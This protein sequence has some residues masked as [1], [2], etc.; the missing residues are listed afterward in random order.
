MVTDR[1]PLIGRESELAELQSMLASSPLVSITGTGGC[2]KTRLALETGERI[3]STT[4]VDGYV[5]AALADVSRAD[6]LIEALVA[7]VGVRERFG[8]TPQE[9]LLEHLGSRR[10]L[11]VLDNCEHLLLDVALLAREL[12]HRAPSLRLLATSR[13]PLAIDGENVLRL[14][15]LSLPEPDDDGVGAIVRSD[16]GRMFVER[17]VRRDAAFALTPRTA[18]AVA[19]ICRELDGLPLALELAAARLDTLSV[20]Q[21]ARELGGKGRLST[22]GT[23]AEP[24]RHSSLRASLDWSYRLLDETERGLLR[25]L[26]VFSGEFNTAAAHGIAAPGERVTHVHDLLQTLERKGLLVPTP[27]DAPQRWRLLS[28]VAEYAGEELARAGERDELADRHLSW[29]KAWAAQADG[30]LL[31]DGHEPIHAEGP[32]LRRALDRALEHDPGGA[33]AMAASLMRHWILAE[34][35]HE[36]HSICSAVIQAVD[37]NAD[38]RARAIVL[39]GGALV[40]MLSEDYEGALA[41][42]QAGLALLDAIEDPGVQAACLMFSSMVLIQ[43]GVDLHGGLANAERAVRLAEQHGDDPLGLAWALV[44][45]AVAAMLCERFQAL[46]EAYEAFLAIPTACEHRTLLAWAEQTVAWAQVSVGSPER[47]LVHIERASTLEGDWPSMTHF[48]VLGF[49]IHALARLGRTDEAIATGEQ[50]LQRA[51][52]SGALQAVPAIE[53]ALATAELLHGA[54]DSAADRANRLL[55]MPHLHT[56]ILARETLARIALARDQPKEAQ[57]HATE[58]EAIARRSGS[59]RHRALA[60]Y[61]TARAAIQTGEKEKGRD[62]LHAALARYAE[63][64]LER[65]TADVL[66]ELALLAADTGEIERCARLAAAGASTRTQLS[67]ALPLGTTERLDTARAQLT[68][69]GASDDWDAAWAQGEQTTL[70]DAIAYARRGRGRRRRST[71]GG[72]PSLTD[73]ER[74][75][76]LLAASG[77]TNPQIAEQLFIARSTVKTHLS[78]I[79]RK[80]DVA[81]RTQ[82]ALATGVR[83]SG[84]PS[85]R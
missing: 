60:E 10:L 8:S 66:D 36:A 41:N 26:S 35:F 73:T 25:R 22:A 11:L 78:S 5:V 76:A 7:A 43:T 62:L 50:A 27:D 21:I 30:R 1:G 28:T 14:G 65:E 17:A 49:R 79:Y 39:C 31:R 74:D 72:W 23:T 53:L 82:L 48:Q 63:L 57:R 46:D 16:A 69:N 54:L 12:C 85:A 77:K 6:R 40:A 83:S 18:Q 71:A 64:G 81:N 34:H 51:S 3:V 4:E 2:G 52:K 68:F 44:T 84:E 58:L 29:L 80:L 9:V 33:L 55:R 70:A 32:N 13:E 19:R 56:L 15:P 37:E 20:E 67:C 38:A 47:A 61:I 24:S 75:V 45:L 59:M 42:T